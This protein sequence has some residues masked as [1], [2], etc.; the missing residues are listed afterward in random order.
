[1]EVSPATRSAETGVVRILLF[2]GDAGIRNLLSA[3]LAS[4]NAE[5]YHVASPEDA[6]LRLESGAG[7]DLVVLDV[8]L[9]G[10]EFIRDV[11]R[12]HPATRIVVTT[13]HPALGS[14]LSALRAG[15]RDYVEKPVTDPR[16]VFK[17][18]RDLALNRTRREESETL[19]EL[20]RQNRDLRNRSILLE[21]KVSATQR[22]LREQLLAQQRSREVFYTDLSRVMAIFDN[23]VDGIV[24]TDT[25]GKVI[26]MNPAAGRMLEL[27]SFTALG[28]P[29]D[30]VVGNQALL[31]VLLEQRN[32]V[33][34]EGLETEVP[35]ARR[36]TGDAS[37]TV[38]TSEVRDY[39][40]K[41]SGVLSLLRDVTAQKKTE[42]LKNQFLSIV[43]HELRTPLTAI[44]SFATI[45]D[46][47]VGGQLPE[48]HRA[49][50]RHIITQTDRLAHEIDKIISLGR[51]EA[52]DFAPDL[53]LVD[54]KEILRAILKP[55]DA[56]AERRGIRLTLEDLTEGHSVYADVRDIRRAIR[57][58]LENALK[59]TDQ[60]G[61]VA[62]RAVPDGTGVLFEV[63][64]TGIGIAPESQEIIFEKFIQLENP[65]T[66]KYG[67]SGL[68]LSFAA[69]IV[70]AH[71][72]KI[73]VE[74]E[75]GRGATFRFRLPPTHAA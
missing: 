22:N 54:V 8:E 18:I 74:S 67:G 10:E 7:F 27:P 32:W 16:A 35:A 2:D 72:S 52:E 37:Y 62:L 13:G 34:E 5:F 24:F 6:V 60:G 33:G 39:Q 59:F 66:R 31:G 48:P 75:L 57:A 49:P 41:V 19:D 55:F 40:G 23:L 30:T 45:L 65:L 58:L 38:Y 47:G 73:E 20:R 26:L 51:L 71:R 44:K 69:E 14:A 50:V 63:S 43:A 17:R 25:E 15:A 53:Q 1:M 21:R 68:G 42:K 64:D 11:A 46:R 12:D 9:A 61:A 70:E 29:L 56:E 3:A 28:Q 36:S 4:E